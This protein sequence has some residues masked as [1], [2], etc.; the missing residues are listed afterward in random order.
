MYEKTAKKFGTTT[1]T[2]RRRPI[3][4]ER[5]IFNLTPAVPGRK[6]ITLAGIQHRYN[7]FS[8]PIPKKDEELLIQ[9]F[10]KH[11]GKAY[12][13]DTQVL[14]VPARFWK[15]TEQFEH[16]VLKALQDVERHL[17]ADRFV[18][19]IHKHGVQAPVGGKQLNEL[20]VTPPRE[21]SRRRTVST[22]PARWA[23]E[24]LYAMKKR[25]SLYEGFF[26]DV[27][28]VFLASEILKRSRETN[29]PVLAVVGAYHA[30]KMHRF[31]ENPGV[32]INY[33]RTIRERVEKYV[34]DNETLL[35]QK[36]SEQ[37]REFTPIQTAFE[38]AIREFEAIRT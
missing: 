21:K 29:K 34:A 12:S 32:A 18:E 20:L 36:L 2:N 24:L 30:S 25:P 23:D 7:H 35:K 27:R 9:L 1:T 28:S 13:E 5:T 6:K 17:I 31:L 22:R 8:G 37:K 14:F 15:R 11:R 4:L 19:N 10:R 26:W 33:L 38:D 16:P 3:N